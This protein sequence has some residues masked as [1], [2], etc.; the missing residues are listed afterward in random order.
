MRVLVAGGAGFIG[1]HLNEWLIDAGHDVLCVDNLSTGRISN[2]AE[3]MRSNHFSFLEHDIEVPLTEKI[4]F[5]FNLASPASPP[6]YQLDPIKT[7]QTNVLG[8]LN[9]L[10]L[11]ES[12]KIPLLQA[13]T[14]EVYGDPAVS[15][16]AE[17]YWG[18]VNP[19]GVR[20][21]YDEGKRAAETLCFDFRRTR[22]VNTKIVRIF[23]TY[24]PKM[25]PRDGRVVSNFLVQALLG[26][27]LT[28]YGDGLQTRSLCYVDDLVTGIT[29]MMNSNFAGPVNLGNPN[30]MTM[31]ELA[32]AVISLT[33]SKSQLV[34]SDLPLD[35][36]KRRCPDISLAKRSLNWQPEV[37]LIDGLMR[38]ADYFAHELGILKTET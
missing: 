35:D 28:V 4:D 27:D 37:E 17:D 20:S 10:R 18:N 38:T 33:G 34:F 29:C 9:L 3:L 25:D 13:S 12:L 1:S 11:A 23:N 22:G 6:A 21:C 15:P 24:G 2:L 5:I 32:Q 19:V 7:F 36:P 16:Q 14:S 8:T 31:L 30:E 26:Q